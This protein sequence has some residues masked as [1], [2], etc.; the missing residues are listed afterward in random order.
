M[1]DEGRRK[2]ER[3]ERDKENLEFGISGIITNKK[4]V[5]VLGLF[6]LWV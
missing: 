5:V 4:V 1:K 6:S 3:Q 2:T